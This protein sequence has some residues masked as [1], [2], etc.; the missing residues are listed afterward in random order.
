MDL[1]YKKIIFTLILLIG[2]IF[3]I[4]NR[5]SFD[6]KN[7]KNIL[8]F[9]GTFAPV[10][11]IFIYALAT[12]LFLPGLILTILAGALFGP[13]FGTI[14]AISGA[15]LGATL[16]FLNARYISYGKIEKMIEGSKLE[17]I[18]KS[19]E[20]EGW[21][22]VAFTRLVPL[23]PFNLLNYSFGLT[24]IKLSEYIWSSF[25]FMIPGTLGYVYLGFTGTEIVTGGENI[26]Q[27][28]LILIAILVTVMYLPHYI[29]KVSKMKGSID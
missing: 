1:N 11:F 18:K 20:E 22:F 3:A 26:I 19:V 14:Y 8:E 17:F 6:N 5:E 9:Y 25:L 23:F 24:K 10:I 12:V 29:K 15:T 4:I 2:I 13:F 16:A 21:K 27:T 7:I 28:I